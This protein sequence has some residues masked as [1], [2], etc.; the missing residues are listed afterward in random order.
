M[1]APFLYLQSLI[2]SG[3]SELRKDSVTEDENDE[4]DEEDDIEIEDENPV[5]IS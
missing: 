2:R 3:P 5:N 1:Q 4:S